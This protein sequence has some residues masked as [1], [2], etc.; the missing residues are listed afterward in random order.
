MDEV[1]CDW[2]RES[3]VSNCSS[4]LELPRNNLSRVAEPAPL[5]FKRCG[6]EPFINDQSLKMT[7][8]LP[9]FG[10]GSNLNRC[11]HFEQNLLSGLSI[12]S[13]QLGQFSRTPEPHC[14]QNAGALSPTVINP[15]LTAHVEFVQTAVYLL[16]APTLQCSD[17]FTL[18]SII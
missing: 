16:T 6:T 11:P 4:I 1:G 13:E 12:S 9:V 8:T 2:A 18:T 7:V 14:G 3:C 17:V 15:R 5:R 10:S